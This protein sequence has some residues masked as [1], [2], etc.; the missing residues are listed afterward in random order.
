[1]W[2]SIMISMKFIYCSAKKSLSAAQTEAPLALQ[3]L[4]LRLIQNSKL[5]TQAPKLR[6][7]LNLLAGP[8][9]LA[10]CE[11]VACIRPSQNS[12]LKIL[13]YE[14]KK[15]QKE[16]RKASKPVQRPLVSELAPEK[17]AKQ[18]SQAA[19]PTSKEG[20]Q[21]PKSSTI[22]EVSE[23]SRALASEIA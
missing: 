5:K 19:R 6:N 14:V 7:L 3:F 8:S 1:M 2:V 4:G 21:V 11:K 18:A 12:K 23:L 15:P 17:A 10:S 20:S 13:S 16:G 22:L 9:H